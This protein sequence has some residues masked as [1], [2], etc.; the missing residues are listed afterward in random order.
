M[1]WSAIAERAA[2]RYRDGL[3]RLPGEPDSRQKQLTRTGNAAWAA[4]LSLLMDSRREE[5]RAWLLRAAERYRESFA[6]APPGSW[7]RLIGTLKALLLARDWAGAVAAARWSL[8][9]EP[10]GAASPIGRYAAV[11]ALLV[12][13]EDAQAARHIATLQAEAAGAFPRPVADALAGLAAGDRSLYADGLARTL[14]SFE[15]QEAYLEDVPVADTVAVLEE[16]AAPRGLS[17]SPRSALLP[18]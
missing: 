4:G 12:L 10:G 6:D 16:L 2:E 5:G 11:L 17:V 8:E 9:Q 1:D 18:A 3:E 15:Q 7:G 13:G 14:A